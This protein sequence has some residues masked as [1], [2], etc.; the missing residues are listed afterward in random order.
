MDRKLN[1]GPLSGFKKERPSLCT[2][3]ALLNGFK[4]M[5]G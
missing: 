4:I 2:G 1:E 3:S 5:A